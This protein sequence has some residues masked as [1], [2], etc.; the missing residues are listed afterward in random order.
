M[1][2]SAVSVVNES[3]NILDSRKEV[4]KGK[5]EMTREERRSTERKRTER[6]GKQ[7]CYGGQ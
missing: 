5:K 7:L 6:R 2:G 3:S 4:Q 1:R